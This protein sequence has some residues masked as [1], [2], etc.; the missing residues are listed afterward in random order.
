MGLFGLLGVLLLSGCG[1]A[2]GRGSFVGRAANAAVFVQWTRS[3]DQLTGSLHEALVKDSAPQVI[4]NQTAPFTGSV[5]GSSVTLSLNGGLGVTNNLTGTLNG[6]HLQLDYPGPTGSVTSLDLKSASSSEFNGDVAALQA[7]VD[8]A[9][10]AARQAQDQ[11]AQ[12]ARVQRDA[13]AVKTDLAALRSAATSAAQRGAGSYSADLAQARRDVAQA[14]RDADHVSAEAR[15][16]DSGTI[17]SDAGQ[18]GSDVGSVQS[19]VGSIQ[20]DQGSTASS[21]TPV[22]DAINTLNQDD[23]ALEGDRTTNPGDVPADAPGADEVRAAVRSARA[24]AST[25]TGAGGSAFAQAQMLEGTAQG[26]ADSAQAVCT[27][28]GG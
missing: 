8:Q 2:G 12:T 1:G 6:D 25:A 13:D 17:C 14:K 22:S 19:D 20:S 27:R 15:T 26:Y 7:R 11:Q 23:A 3:G 28:A 4:D 24:L 16:V 21:T 9:N 10:Q 5:S 18:V